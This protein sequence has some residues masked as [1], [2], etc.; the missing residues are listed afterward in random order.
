[1]V[2]Y[3]YAI[4]CSIHD[5]SCSVAHNYVHVSVKIKAY[6][7]VVLRCVALRCVALR[8]V[9]LYCIALHCIV[10]NCIVKPRP[11]RRCISWLYCCLYDK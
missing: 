2:L 3:N 6:C 10:L 1:M 5:V 8:C 4:T 11:T 9:A 7:I